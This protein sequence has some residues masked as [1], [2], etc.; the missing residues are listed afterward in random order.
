MTFVTYQP[1]EGDRAEFSP[2]IIKYN[3]LPLYQ[4][5]P[6]SVITPVLPTVSNPPNFPGLGT[7]P[8]KSL[9]PGFNPRVN[10]PIRKFKVFCYNHYTVL[11]KASSVASITLKLSSSLPVSSS[12]TNKPQSLKH[13]RYRVLLPPSLFLRFVIISPPF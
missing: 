11:T 8:K 5:L 2:S 1:R 10:F 3:R 13:S 7:Q 6:V 9:G 12:S 4:G